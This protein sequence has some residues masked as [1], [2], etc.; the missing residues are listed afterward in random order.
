MNSAEARPVRLTDDGGYKFSPCF[1]AAG[2]E[3]IYTL[4]DGM[5]LMHLMRLRLP[6]G[7]VEP[8]HKDTPLSELEPS[9][10]ADGRYLACV[11]LRGVLSLGLR[12]RDRKQNTTVEVA[13]EPGFCG[14]R[15]PAVAPD[16]SRVLYSFAAGGWQ[17]LYSVDVRGGDRKVLTEGAGIDNWP[18]FSPDGKRVVF[19]SSRGGVFDL[20][21]MKPDGKEVR[22]LTHGPFRHVRPRFSPNGDHIAFS[23]FQDGR[24]RV[25]VMRADGSRVRCVETKS[26]GDD[27]PS[28]HPDGKR[29]VV[30]SEVG[31]KHDL[32]LVHA[33]A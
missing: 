32:Y 25:F 5:T 33:P 4:W 26:E 16:N 24:C 23:G 18:S 11:A 27:Y 10:S 28:W 8:L 15:S 29:L 30:V 1:S 14:M 9:V 21:V 31:G 3:V 19:G 22:R 20:Y 6:E 2:R 17:K 7:T 13:P 12:I